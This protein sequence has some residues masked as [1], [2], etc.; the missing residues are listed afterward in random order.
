MNK[1]RRVFLLG[2][3][4]MGMAPLAL[5]LQGAGIQVEA[6]DDRFREPLR[7][8]LEQSGV[9]VLSEPTPLEN[10]D[11]VIRS[12]AI[13]EGSKLV[14]PWL[15]K[16]IPVFRRGEFLARFTANRKILAVVGSHGKTTTSGMLCWALDQVGFDFSYLEKS[17]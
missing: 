14:Q 11:C 10:P 1:P 6:Y 7:S 16:K 9:Q 17:D 2:A 8:S 12:S 4:G 3:G 13:P 5:Y 15:A